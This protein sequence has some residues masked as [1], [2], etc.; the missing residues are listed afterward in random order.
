MQTPAHLRFF[1]I[2]LGAAPPGFSGRSK[3]DKVELQGSAPSESPEGPQA[4][5]APLIAALMNVD[6]ALTGVLRSLL[7]LHTPGQIFQTGS[8]S[9]K[10]LWRCGMEQDHPRLSHSS[11]S[12]SNLFPGDSWILLHALNEVGTTT[13]SSSPGLNSRT[14]LFHVSHCE[15]QFG[16]QNLH[17]SCTSQRLQ[18]PAWLCPARR[19]PAGFGLEKLIQCHPVPGTGTP[20]RIPGFSKPIQA[21]DGSV[22]TAQFSSSFLPHP[23]DPR[24]HSPP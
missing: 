23:W 14:R 20:S 5:L 12:K 24:S 19:I 4:H 9:R 15:F 17:M 10:S 22:H 2:F 8:G 6:P 13:A 3:L 21:L 16:E 18:S 7:S 11:N 1:G